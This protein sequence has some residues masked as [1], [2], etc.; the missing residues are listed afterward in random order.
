VIS[1]AMFD[2]FCV[3]YDRRIN[4]AL[5]EVGLKSVYHTC[6]GMMAIL[7]RI[8]NNHTDA[9]ETLSPTGVGGD[10][11]PRDRMHVKRILGG[12]VSLIGGIDQG[13]LLTEGTP[14]EI[15]AD[16]HHLFQTFGVGGGYIASASDH[17]FHT[18][19]ENLKVMARAAKEC[20]Y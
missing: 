1:P 5:R 12:K 18:P 15:R 16:I 4:D 3:P 6:G 8:P 7:D 13:R 10:I 19:V 11:E 20:R 9:S 17:F 2:E 14:E